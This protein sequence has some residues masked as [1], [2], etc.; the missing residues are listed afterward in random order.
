MALFMD[1]HSGMQGITEAQLRQEHER[2][3]R[4][5]REEDLGVRVLK[6]W[7]DPDAGK[8]F[9]LSEG[10]SRDAVQ[11]AHEKAG[12]PTTEIYELAYEVE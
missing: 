4:T 11:R 3:E 8:V 12:H 7:A 10:P 6:S 5:Q 2:D 9:C 1:V